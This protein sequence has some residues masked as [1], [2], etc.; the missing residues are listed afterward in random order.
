MTQAIIY[1]NLLVCIVQP[2][3]PFFNNFDITQPQFDEKTSLAEIKRMFESVEQMSP[4]L[5][6]PGGLAADEPVAWFQPEE[7]E[8]FYDDGSK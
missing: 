3:R 2:N 4:R 5:Y 1:F 6:V 7:D 8:P